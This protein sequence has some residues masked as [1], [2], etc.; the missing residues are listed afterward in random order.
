M[1]NNQLL[2]YLNQKFVE[3]FS[4]NRIPA[5]KCPHCNKGIIE[6]KANGLSY[7]ETP[8]SQALRSDDNW[9]PHWLEYIFSATFFCKNCGGE[10]YACGKG[11]H[12]SWHSANPDEDGFE[13]ISFTPK[14]FEP[15]IKLIEI[16]AACPPHISQALEAAFAI[17]WSDFS[18]GGN[19][20][21]IALEKLV[22]E[23]NPA[24]SKIKNL[25][26]KLETLK[27]SYPDLYELFMSIK[28]IGNDG[29]HDDSLRECDLA[30]GFQA[31]QEA[32]RKFYDADKKKISN[33]AKIVNTLRGRPK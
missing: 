24:A 18:S 3:S 16:P 6:L 21:R 14:Y 26:K 22:I 13:E 5:W 32:L 7:Q 27:T 1:E 8:K 19:K 30:F 11:K 10:I 12:T 15:A 4:A 20:L 2:Q 33:L 17:A 23:F 28:W 31:M 29:S 9:E 25:H